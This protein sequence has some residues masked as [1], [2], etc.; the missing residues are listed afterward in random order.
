MNLRPRIPE[1][2]RSFDFDPVPLVKASGDFGRPLDKPRV[3]PRGL[4]VGSLS[5]FAFHSILFFFREQTGQLR[6]DT[7]LKKPTAQQTTKWAY[8]DEFS[9]FHRK[10]G[11]K[12]FTPIWH[13]VLEAE[14]MDHSLENEWRVW[15]AIRRYS[16]GNLSDWAV[17]GMPAQNGQPKPRPLTQDRLAEIL[18]ISPK[19]MSEACI[20]LR[21]KGYLRDHL[22]LFPED[23]N[24]SSPLESSKQDPDSMGLSFAFSSHRSAFFS[25]H[26]ETAKMLSEA[27]AARK[28][29]ND[30]IRKIN[31]EVLVSY[32]AA[33]RQKQKEQAQQNQQ[34]QD[35]AETCPSLTTLVHSCAQS[36]QNEGEYKSN[37]NFQYTTEQHPH[38]TAVESATPQVAADG[39]RIPKPVTPN[40]SSCATPRPLKPLNSKG[41]GTSD[42]QS[43][44]PAEPQRLTDRQHAIVQA[45]PAELLDRLHDFPTVKLLDRIDC[46]LA[47]AP[48][49]A[50]AQ[51]IAERWLTITA[52]GILASL[53]DD[54]GR[55]W[56]K[57]EA[58]RESGIPAAAP[59]SR[60]DAKRE[61]LLR[62]MEIM[63]RMQGRVS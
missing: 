46:K 1:A 26:I 49:S 17:D 3:E 14:M 24:D 15:S 47:G 54:V 5:P 55:A 6:R 30:V 28:A 22:Y 60:Q 8:K 11:R 4:Y 43:V 58:D 41:I 51:R 13:S 25:E 62:G 7:K 50:F 61:R 16:W 20:F 34:K 40:V 63:D 53:A 52:L 9:A 45:I 36:N 32:R 31:Y 38:S 10:H 23:K 18:G 56:K 42:S 59:V 37:C 44:S 19:R 57:A 33:L 12:Y 27:E 48:L 35:D 29:A 2:R 39:V 21:K